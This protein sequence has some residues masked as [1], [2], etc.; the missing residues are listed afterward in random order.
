MSS[1]FT[2]MHGCWSKPRLTNGAYTTKITYN[3]DNIQNVTVT[4]LMKLIKV[5]GGVD[6]YCHALT[7]ALH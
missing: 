1:N 7:S 6:V 5:H 2:L 4:L 3:N